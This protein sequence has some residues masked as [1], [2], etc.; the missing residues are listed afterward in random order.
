MLVLLMGVSPHYNVV[1]TDLIFSSEATCFSYEQA[2]GKRQADAMNLFLKNWKKDGDNTVVNQAV[3]W[4]GIQHPRGTC[5]PTTS[6]Q[7]VK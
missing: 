3:A 1:K 6:N 4:A 7:T 5:I 2:M